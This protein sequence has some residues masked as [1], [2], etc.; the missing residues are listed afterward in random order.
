MPL[1]TPHTSDFIEH[2]QGQLIPFTHKK[3]KTK[4]NLIRISLFCAAAL[5]PVF[6]CHAATFVVT[7]TAD[8]GPGTLRQNIAAASSGDNIIF[9]TNLSGAMI[10]LT[11]GYLVLS[12]NISIDA[13]ALPGGIRIDGSSSD[14]V[15]YVTNVSA[16]ALTSLI[17]TNGRNAAGGGG[18]Y[19]DHSTLTLN[20]CTMT[21]NYTASGIGGGIYNNYGTLI[22]NRCTV[23]GNFAGSGGGGICNIQG[24]LT[25]NECTVV[26]NNDV[27]SGAG[28]GAGIYNLSSSGILTVNQSTVT[29]NNTGNPQG[30]GGI[31]NYGASFITNSIVA[32]NS[33]AN[34]SG[35]DIIADTLAMKLGGT[36]IV[37]HYTQV[38]GG[39]I[40]GSTPINAAPQLAPLGGYGSLN[41]TMPPLPGS[42]AIDA[43]SDSITNL[44]PTDQRGFSRLA[45]LHVDIG[46][47]EFGSGSE[48]VTTAADSGPG[49]LRQTISITAPGD[50]IYFATNLSGSIITL[51]GSQINVNSSL[52]I[53][54]S[55]LPNGIQISGNG[56]TRIFN[57][58]SGNVVAMNALFIANGNGQF[59]PVNNVGG[60][61]I[62]NAG[63]LTLNRCTFSGNTAN[64][65]SYPSTTGGGGIYNSGQLTLNECTLSGNHAD[66]DSSGGGGAIYNDFSGN[67]FVNQSTLTGN[68]AD[69][70]GQGGGIYNSGNLTL[71]NSIVAG[72]TANSGSGA[73]VY[74]LASSANLNGAN[75][76]QDFSGSYSG[77]S[78]LTGN[79]LLAEIAYYGGPT[80]TRPPLLG[81]P[82]INACFFGTTFFT[83]QRGFPRIIASIPDIGAAEYQAGT[84]VTT[85][86]DSGEGSLRNALVYSTN[87]STITF[88]SSMSGQTITLNGGELLLGQNLNID[89]SSLSN[90]VTIKAAP[91]NRVL[92]I[93]AGVTNVLTALTLTNG[94][95]TMGGCVYNSG[96]LAVN[97]CTVTGNVAD[98]GGGFY[99]LGTLTV[100]ESTVTGNSANPLEIIQWGFEYAPP[101]NS[102]P[103]SP[104]IGIGI[105]T[106]HHAGPSIYTS[107]SGNGSPHS[108]SSTNWAVGDYYQFLVTSNNNVGLEVIWD[109]ISSST[110]PRDF[111]FF[112]S[113]NGIN[114]T[115]FGST[116]MVSNNA[117][118]NLWTTTTPLTTTRY[119]LD[120][121]GVT[122]L[123]NAPA[124]YF[125]LV[126]ASTSSAGGG[127]VAV[128]GTDRVDNFTV[129]S[130]NG[131]GGI[132]NAGTLAVNQSTVTG[133]FNGGICNSNTMT[134]NNS[135]VAGNN[136][137]GLNGSW[138][139]GNNLTNGNPLLAT[140]GSYGGPTPTMPPTN[141]SPAIDTGND[142]TASTFIIDQR[143]LPRISGQHVDIGAAEYQV[144]VI[145][146]TNPPLLTPLLSTPGTGTFGFNFTNLTGAS[147]TIFASTNVATPINTW[148]NLGAITESPAGSGHF[149][150]IDPQAT[151]NNRRFYRIRSP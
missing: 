35:A 143:G 118:P 78:P 81:S 147:F 127:T 73:D 104:E 55:A 97:R 67:L 85:N 131:G 59:G 107:P 128:A 54:A 57:V 27:G 83:D 15:F 88:A 109:Q 11:N 141:G 99:N 92:E 45:G 16:G 50:T 133:N 46:A 12:N 1:Q 105:A 37:Q 79:P 69:Y 90:G 22:L 146:A 30:S 115:Q 34:I 135:I 103:Y 95:S 139:G 120:L 70:G 117:A 13:S 116:Y 53:D 86:S 129:Y 41:P 130:L 36:N 138:T 112:Y 63:Q 126:D 6:A 75:L 100:N 136:P 52:T 17:I 111:N 123:N 4:Q 49:S 20:R 91:V 148:S 80:P 9:A 62:F 151:N 114:F 21:G 110:G 74:N 145:V 102:G 42:P 47:V 18:I 132:Y 137:D 39:T 121:S 113:T 32:G 60:G 122:A 134:I 48:Q 108:F 144:P 119:T 38:G 51:N 8:S 124:V 25:V 5:L 28:T 89:G 140:L 33:A 64:N 68:S 84:V 71:Y 125:R 106:G 58:A 29:G 94:S 43:A 76:V 87:G 77:N 3:M 101:S 66:N 98:S 65:L 96:N 149:Q 44:F 40:S 56:F 150:F 23:A 82:A 31:Y 14:R 2:R 93:A 24:S 61:G 72:N 26:G 10:T 142:T 7:N 19:S